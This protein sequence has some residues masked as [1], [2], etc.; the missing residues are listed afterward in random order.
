MGFSWSFP[1]HPRLSLH[2]SAALRT[3]SWPLCLDACAPYPWQEV[4]LRLTLSSP[5]ET[6]PLLSLCSRTG[7]F[8]TA[9]SYPERH[10]PVPSAYTAAAGV[11][12]EYAADSR[13]V[14]PLASHRRSLP[15]LPSL[16]ASDSPGP[17]PLAGC[18]PCSRIR[19]SSSTKNMTF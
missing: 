9:S 10:T 19:L 15:V 12:L 18:A 5:V 3:L 11:H 16:F 13:L 6:T 1:G 7:S 8:Q 4:K 14:W 2:T 17:L